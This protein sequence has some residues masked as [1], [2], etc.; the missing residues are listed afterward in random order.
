MHR[1]ILI[2]LGLFCGLVSSLVAAASLPDAARKAD[3]IARLPDGGWLLAG[4]KGLSLLDA[5]GNPQAS[6]AVRGKHLETRA[7]AQGAL[8][9]LLDSD[10]QQ[11]L[12]LDVQGGKL[13]ERGRIP[14]PAWSVESLCLFRDVQQLDHLYLL[15]KDGRAQ[16]WLL[17][18]GPARLLRELALPPQ[19][20][21]CS[22]DDAR[23]ILYVAEQGAAL[24][25]YAAGGEGV[26]ARSVIA[27]PKPLGKLQAGAGAVTVLPGGLALL[28]AGGE[29]LHLLTRTAQGWRIQ[30]SRRVPASEAMALI[31]G[32]LWLREEAAGWRAQNLPLPGAR[33]AVANLPVIAPLVQ[34]D[35][36]QRFGDAADDPAIWIHPGDPKLSR[37]LGTNKKQGLLSYDLQGRETQLLEAGRL[38]NVDVR[39]Q[40]RFGAQQLDLAVATQRDELALAL[41]QIDANGQVRDAG[42]I[43]TGLENIYGVCLY[44][45]TEGGLEAFVNDK[46]GRI[47][48]YRI[49]FDGERF[50]G[51]KLR[52]L[53]VATQPEGCVVDDRAA[54][55]FVGEEDRGIW[56]VSAR[57]DSKDAP[58]LVMSVGRELVAD[59]E[60]LAIYHGASA[61]YLIASSQGNDSYVVVDAAPPY[62]YRG[63]FRVG[64]N[65]QAG[66]DGVSDTDGLEVSARNFGGAFSEGMLV[67]QDGYK[68]LP[69]AAQNF[70]YV[71]WR[72]IARSLDLK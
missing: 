61:S 17:S 22:A 33:R 4:K 37:V 34:T 69:D 31:D 60:G 12:L 39:Q 43:A 63:G 5:G 21:S 2:C 51:R 55:L 65:A 29:R 50:S 9:V 48:H 56:A 19:A 46:D 59:V 16:Q 35:P 72:D 26:P 64:I 57:A 1:F 27:A 14:S 28:E 42:R 49:D 8:A 52:E 6:L 70:K 66:I 15:G 54:R 23:Q 7:Q 62:R 11:T 71:P 45:P 58:Q 30:H 41:F 38:N 40:V 25:A 68:R 32:Q 18:G 10:S 3:E 47:A 53:R 13:T 67:L 24:W 36:V 20:D 44:Q